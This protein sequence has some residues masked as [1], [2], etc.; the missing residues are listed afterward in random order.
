MAIRWPLIC[1]LSDVN[2]SNFCSSALMAIR[3]PDLV[4]AVGLWPPV[5]VVAVIETSLVWLNAMA[6]RMKGACGLGIEANIE[7]PHGAPFKCAMSHNFCIVLGTFLFFV[8]FFN[9]DLASA[10]R[11]TKLGS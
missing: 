10:R 6:G 1:A 11:P 3:R 2:Y 7:H 4:A 5:A 8:L 9:S